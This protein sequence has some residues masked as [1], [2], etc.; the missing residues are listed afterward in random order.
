MAAF[1]HNRN[2]LCAARMA[3]LQGVERVYVHCFTDGRD[4]A[5]NSGEGYLSQLQQKMR[6]LSVGKIATVSGRYYAM[7]R[8]KRWERIKRAFDAM[9]HGNGEALRFIDAVQGVR[10]SYNKGVFDEFIVPFVLTDNRG[11]PLAKIKPDDWCICFNFRADRVREITRAL[12]RNS[13]LNPEGGRNL[14]GWEELDQTIPRDEAPKELKYVCMTQYDQKF[15]L[16]F[17]VPPESLDNILANIMA[18]QH[19]EICEWRSQRSTR[20]LPI[21]SMVE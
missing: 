2:H 9:V 19:C 20:T 8:D 6:E 5:P 15:K 18:N 21:S 11:E 12:C 17:V 14:E 7:D 4:T 16:P 13:N 10:D 1:T 3:K